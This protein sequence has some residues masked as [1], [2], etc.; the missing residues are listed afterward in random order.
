MVRAKDNA[1]VIKLKNSSNVLIEKVI[2]YND[3][4][5]MS[6][7]G[8]TGANHADANKIDENKVMQ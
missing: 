3:V 2:Y 7:T 8:L 6:P 1:A 4:W 5:G